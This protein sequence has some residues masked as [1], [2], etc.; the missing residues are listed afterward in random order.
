[1]K[2][3]KG[4]GTF[5]LKI[6]HLWPRSTWGQKIHN[7]GASFPKI[8]VNI[9]GFFWPTNL[10]KLLQKDVPKLFKVSQ[11]YSNHKSKDT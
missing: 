6:G 2:G 7:V 1:M 10:S 8:G 11:Q 5:S 9:I 4:K 3:E